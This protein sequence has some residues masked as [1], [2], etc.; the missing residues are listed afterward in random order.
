MA[1]YTRAGDKGTT[2]LLGG[3]KVSKSDHRV[4]AY[5]QVDELNCAIG[6]AIA[7]APEDLFSEL[8]ETVQGD[9]LS[10]GGFLAAPDPAKVADALAR[11][12][13]PATRVTELEAAIDEADAELAPLDAFVLPGGTMKAALLHQARAVCRRAERD[14][15]A[16]GESATVPSEFIPYLNRLSDLLFTLARLA[17]HRA[18]VADTTW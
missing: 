4:A 9:L 1:I 2:A 8:L 6:T 17:N 16:L 11:A 14:V 13:L 18:N 10:I 5:G 15:V 12:K 3:G 7:C